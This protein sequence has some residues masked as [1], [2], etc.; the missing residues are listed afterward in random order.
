MGMCGIRP[1]IARR[2]EVRERVAAPTDRRS[3][4][5]VPAIFAY[6]HPKVAPT[7]DVVTKEGRSTLWRQIGQ[8]GGT[9]VGKNEWDRTSCAWGC[10]TASM[11]VRQRGFGRVRVLADRG[12][13]G[14]RYRSVLTDR[15]FMPTILSRANR[16]ALEDALEGAGLVALTAG[17]G[18]PVR[19]D[20]APAACIDHVCARGDSAWQA[21]PAVRWPDVPVPERWLS[22]HF[23][24][25]VVF[26]CPA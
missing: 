9:S 20:S 14:V 24:L 1:R 26:T 21:A 7:F 10:K 19:R 6:W 3:A 16:A 11:A 18:D 4:C 22:D 13:L 8:T 2:S 25:S 23:G 5:P 15:P 12:P 17:A